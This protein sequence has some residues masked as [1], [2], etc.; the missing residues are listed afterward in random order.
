MSADPALAAGKT[1]MSSAS[2][3][4]RAL[5]AVKAA[6]RLTLQWVQSQTRDWAVMMVPI[7]TKVHSWAWMYVS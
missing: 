1:L 2:S 4:E 6:R 3:M 5:L 7:Q